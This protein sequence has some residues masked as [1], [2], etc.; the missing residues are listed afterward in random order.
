MLRNPFCRGV[1]RSHLSF[2]KTLILFGAIL[3][4]PAFASAQTE[5]EMKMLRMYF[6]EDELVLSPTRSLKPLSQVAEN[7]S[8]VTADEIQAM[9]THMLSKV[10][11]RVTGLYIYNYLNDYGTSENVFIQGSDFYGDDRRTLILLNGMPWNFLAGGTHTVNTIP[12]KIVK[13]I[14]IIKG[15]ASSAWGSSLGGVINVVTKDTGDK[16]VPSG[17][18]SA[19]YGERD[20]QNYNGEIMGK[21]GKVR[22]YLHADRTDSDGLRGNRHFERDSLYSKFDISI[23]PDIKLTLTAGYSD[24]HFKYY[25][26]IDYD[27]SSYGVFRAFFTTAALTAEITDNLSAEASLYRLKQKFASERNVLSDTGLWDAVYGIDLNAGDTFNQYIYDE[28]TEGGTIKVL[29][30]DSVQNAVMGLDISHGELDQI[31]RSAGSDDDINHPGISKWAVFVNDTVSIGNLSITPGLR[32][33]QNN[34]SSDFTSPSLGLTYR[35]GSRTVLKASVARGFAYPPITYTSSEELYLKPN[36]DL[37]PEK[38]W[39]YQAGIE[40]IISEFLKVKTV[41]FH[42]DM[43][44]EI[45]HGTDAAS[46][47]GIFIN[48]DGKAK[49]TGAELELET[50]PVY[51]VSLKTGLSYV[52]KELVPEENFPDKVNVTNI[53]DC[54]IIV[55][56]DDPKS[57]SAQLSGN[58]TWWDFDWDGKYNTFIWDMSVSKKVYS[59][60]KLSSDVFLTVNNIFNGSY[61]NDATSDSYNIPRRWVEAGVRLEF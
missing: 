44:N 38:V 18:V 12:V 21:A 4:S 22:Y 33:D 25:D 49:R 9:N 53:Y 50:A 37:K 5:E 39:S 36:P 57:L 15:P 31:S 20:S 19:S 14:E 52:H 24:P 47:K 59:S 8:I 56:Y 55:R 58:Y 30:N 60:E 43:K 28:E 1:H 7:I 11:E 16:A 13:R 3:F 23:N 46:G 29:W 27:Y 41:V 45:Q 32:Y 61:S 10:L 51:N 40:S 17:S 48:G 35:I 42:H 2:F 6:K 34:V 26:V 54:N